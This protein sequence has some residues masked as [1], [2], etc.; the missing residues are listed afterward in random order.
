MAFEATADEVERL[1]PG[2]PLILG[3][4]WLSLLKPLPEEIY[5]PRG[6]LLFVM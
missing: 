4:G 2:R 1:E 5:R 3:V 6:F